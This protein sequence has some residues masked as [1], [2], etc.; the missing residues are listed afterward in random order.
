MGTWTLRVNN[1]KSL[2][3][4]YTLTLRPKRL[5]LKPHPETLN[6]P[7]SITQSSQFR[8]Q[9]SCAGPRDLKPVMPQKVEFGWVGGLEFRVPGLPDKP[10][11]HV[12]SPVSPKFHTTSLGESGCRV[13]SLKE[14]I[15]IPTFIATH[16]H[17]YIP[18]YARRYIHT[19]T[20][21]HLHTYI[22]MHVRT[23]VCV[24]MHTY[25]HQYTHACM[26]ACKHT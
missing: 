23:Y 22:L 4:P 7:Y 18:T 6:K 10:V 8:A 11:A 1:P 15:Y 14:E 2:L 17:T 26:H 5:I 24:C 13:S 9:A 19:Y 16:L 21:T 25:R 3:R 12:F 20:P